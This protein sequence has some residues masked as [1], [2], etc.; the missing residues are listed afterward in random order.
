MTKQEHIDY[1]LRTAERDWKVVQSLYDTKEYVY[2]LFFGHL[3]LE[4]IAKALWIKNNASNQPPKIHNI[5]SILTQAGVEITEEQNIFFLQ[6]NVFQLE[7]RYPDYKDK[8][9][10]N[11]NAE[12][13]LVILNQI[14][15]E[16]SWLLKM[17][18]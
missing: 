14:K 1:W 3:V 7:G 10:R 18:Q 11:Y 12:K 4:K 13:T 8:I 5:V 16:R 2:S 17:L 9:F 15:N 6:I